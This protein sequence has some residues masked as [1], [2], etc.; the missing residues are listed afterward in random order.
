[1]LRA[2]AG[3]TSLAKNDAKAVAREEMGTSR[4]L[5]ALRLLLLV[6]LAGRKAREADP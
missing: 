2:L 5:L 3:P 6:V 1:M 4:L